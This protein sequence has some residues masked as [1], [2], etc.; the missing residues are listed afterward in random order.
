MISRT[1]RATRIPLLLLAAL[2][3]SVAIPA[4]SQRLG[5]GVVLWTSPDGSVK[6]GSVVPVFIK[7]NIQKLYVVGLPDGSRKLELPLW[8]IEVFPSKAK[9][10]AR[11]KAFGEYLSIYMV[12]ARD[13]LPIREEPVNSARRVYRLKDGQTVKVLAKAKG[14]AVTTGGEAL[15]GDWFEVISDDGTRGFVFSYAMKQYDESKEGPPESLVAKQASGK[16][17]IVFSRQWRPEYFQE[18]LDDQRLDLDLFSLR[19]GMF[20]DSVRKQIRIELPAASQV[21]NYSAITEEG[22]AY[23]FEGTALRI[24]VEGDRRLV[25]SWTDQA[26]QASLSPGTQDLAAAAV[27][28]VPAA[29]L[30]SA[31]YG[32][33]GSAAFVVPSLEPRDAI[34][35]EELRRQKLMESFLDKFGTDWTSDAG[36]RLLLSRSRR[37]TWTGRNALPTG[38]L[39]DTSSDTG[40]I[41]FR[42]FLSAE[43]EK[44]WDGAFSIRFD[45]KASD[46]GGPPER[47]A[48]ADLLYRITPEGLALA[49]ARPGIQGLTV[50]EADPR[51]D[52]VTFAS[53]SKTK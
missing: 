21:F 16:V 37:I 7:S 51:F 31:S 11:I 34:R 43:L 46:S 14:E 35:L 23:L 33:E 6:A 15:P 17:D 20:S 24:I 19:Y 13:G 50:M 44:A 40:E 3:L 29:A 1:L 47:S 32:A 45:A 8:Q 2:C 53:V 18:M 38:F 39:P 42:L 30:A 4:C 36:G 25:A 28:A 9:A 49:P 10:E 26:A 12:A 52:P 5:W 48:W 22:G 27:P 41:A